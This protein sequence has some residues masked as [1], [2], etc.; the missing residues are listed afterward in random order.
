ME[1]EEPHLSSLS[2]CTVS[3]FWCFS[4]R[5]TPPPGWEVE[6][7]TKL[8]KKKRLKWFG[9]TRGPGVWLHDMSGLVSRWI[10]GRVSGTRW[11]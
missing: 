4:E 9:L 5:D 1:G 6:H 3:P 10:T 2:L 7:E 8:G 11:G